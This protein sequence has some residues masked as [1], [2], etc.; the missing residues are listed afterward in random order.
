MVRNP[1]FPNKIS[2]IDLSPENAEFIIFWTKNPKPMLERLRELNGSNFY[3]QFTLTPYGKRIEHGLPEKSE[4]T[5]TFKLLSEKI[6]AKKII[7]RYDPV[8]ISSVYTVE[9]HVETFSKFAD[10]LHGYFERCIFSFIDYYKK[11]DGAF[12]KNLIREPTISEMNILAENFSETAKKYNFS[13]KTCA[14]K[15]DFS[16][17]GIGSSSCIDKE[18]I[19]KITNRYIKVRKDKNQRAECGCI[20]SVDIGAYNTCANGCVYCYAGGNK[21]SAGLDNNVFKESPL[22]CGSLKENDIITERK[23]ESIFINN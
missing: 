6:G 5:N 8:L 1:F 10:T 19:E 20:E 4:L 9:Y 7:W 3:F 13:I 17:Y 21:V 15:Y 2:K 14:E 18:L 23:R 11:I 22:L 16:K 12:T